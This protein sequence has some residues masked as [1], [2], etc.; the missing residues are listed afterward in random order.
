MRKIIFF[1][2]LFLLAGGALFAQISRGGTA[3]VSSRTAPVRAS[4]WFFAGTRGT[5]V[6]GEQVSVLQVSGSWAE[7]RSSS[8]PSLT[9]WVALSNL[10]ARRIVS[11]A[12]GATPAE[13]ALAGKGFDRDVE[14]A[15]RSGNNLNFYDV[16]RTEAITVSDAALLSFI[17]GGRLL[18]G[19]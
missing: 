10:S 13:V 19:E 11:S 18:T 4:T 12:A 9:G 7:V 16:D 6:M 17:T 14:N 15:F 2:A 1:A 8:N 5:L 3:W